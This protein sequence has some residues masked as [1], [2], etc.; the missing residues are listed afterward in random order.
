MI[1]A[2]RPQLSPVPA[3]RSVSFRGDKPPQNGDNPAALWFT[4]S[5]S[6][7]LPG[8]IVRDRFTSIRITDCRDREPRRAD[9]VARPG[10]MVVARAGRFR[11]LRRQGREGGDQGREDVQTVG[12]Q[13][14]IR[15][16]P[17]ARRRL[18]LLRLHAEPQLRYRRPEPDAGRT[19]E[20][21]RAIYHLSRSRTA[22]QHRS[23]AL[24]QAA[25][26]AAAGFP[27]R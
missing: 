19:E 24:S 23:G 4:L 25:A 14:E 22:Q 1:A 15:R 12:V 11:G 10:T 13:R 8:N 16:P 17:Q 3:R 6:E 5:C 21:R 7:S 20:N 9:A 2:A 26:I 27:A 18:Y